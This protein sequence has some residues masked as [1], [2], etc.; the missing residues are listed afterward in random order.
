M[1]D[2]QGYRLPAGSAIGNGAL[3]KFLGLVGRS[4]R[5]QFFRKT[6]VYMVGVLVPSARRKRFSSSE[7]AAVKE[8]KLREGTTAYAEKPT[9]IWVPRKRFSLSETA[10]VTC[11]S[12]G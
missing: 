3:P 7:T 2:C 11:A 12:Q 6:D 5:V 4:V 9:F 10:V 8:F 1:R